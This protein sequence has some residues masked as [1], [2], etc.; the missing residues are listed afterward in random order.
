MCD[1]AQ[2]ML[3]FDARDADSV[4]MS[5]GI[6]SYVQQ[7]ARWNVVVEGPSWVTAGLFWKLAQG[8]AV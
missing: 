2:V 7:S 3:V 8:G 5:R 4:A 6:A 1:A